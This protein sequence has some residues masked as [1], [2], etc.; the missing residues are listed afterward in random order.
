MHVCVLPPE[1]VPSDTGA[2]L[3]TSPKPPRRAAE[4]PPRRR[5]ERAIRRTHGDFERSRLNDQNIAAELLGN[6]FR[7]VFMNTRHSLRRARAA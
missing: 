5:D 6:V 3:V 4:V 2:R 7:I 1:V